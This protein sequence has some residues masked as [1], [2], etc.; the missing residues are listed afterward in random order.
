MSP[1]LNSTTFIRS[2]QPC[3]NMAIPSVNAILQ[4]GHKGDTT[5][6]YQSSI[7]T[8]SAPL[9]VLSQRL[10]VD[11]VDPCAIVRPPGALDLPRNCHKNR[12]L[13]RLPYL[14]NEPI[15]LPACCSSLSLWACRKSRNTNVPSG[16]W[17]SSYTYVHSTGTLLFQPSCM[18][19]R[20]IT[21]GRLIT[22]VKT[23]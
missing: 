11:V 1:P 7:L 18:T 2:T 9:A 12:R 21:V 19:E 22:I 20:P 23:V 6:Q 13:E 16:T 3:K 15:K 4:R 14:Q 17:V 5:L 10:T 8:T